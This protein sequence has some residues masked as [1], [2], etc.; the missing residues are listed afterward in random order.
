M[1]SES[2]R[3]KSVTAGK[4]PRYEQIA[5]YLRGRV[6][7]SSF[8]DRLPS[9]AELCAQFSV[10]RMTARQAVQVVVTEGL[11]QRRR[12]AGTYV[13]TQPV[14]RDLG[15]PLS[16][17]ESM[18]RRGMSASSRILKWGEVRP[19]VDER[20]ALGLSPGEGAQVLERLRLAD[21]VPMAIERAL[22]PLDLARD[23]E[24]DLEIGSL[25]S[26]FE[27]A[28][29]YPTKALA[30]VWARHASKR[31]R[32]LLGLAASGI[33]LCEERTISDQEGR[34]LERTVT[35]YAS[36]RYSFRAV[37]VREAPAPE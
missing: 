5:D 25:H 8:G 28:G 24:G 23:I 35:F 27:R 7:V 10:S 16:F 3:E 34:P 9:D 20:E 12:G 14:L 18:R 33:V 31:Q 37:L 36:S 29:R 32:E 21:N 2:D 6:S 26:A 17:T 1:S 11:V 15:S 30:E 19:T 22:M 4:Q 13:R